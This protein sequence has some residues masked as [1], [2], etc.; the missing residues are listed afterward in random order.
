MR[1]LFEKNGFDLLIIELNLYISFG[2][3]IVAKRHI[4]HHLAFTFP[5][6]MNYEL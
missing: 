4:Y 5:S 3:L 2:F 1:C 6:G